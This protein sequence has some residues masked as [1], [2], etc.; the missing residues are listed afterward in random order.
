MSI[1]PDVDKTNSHLTCIPLRKTENDHAQKLSIYGKSRPLY[2]PSVTV[3]NLCFPRDPPPLQPG[4]FVTC[5]YRN[6]SRAGGKWLSDPTALRDR[7][8]GSGKGPAPRLRASD[9]APARPGHGSG[10]SH[11]RP[12]P[13][14]GLALGRARAVSS[15]RSPP[16]SPHAQI[17]THP[18]R[19]RRAP[20][21][22]G[23]LTLAFVFPAGSAF[24]RGRPA[25][26]RSWIARNWNRAKLE[27]RSE[28]APDALAPTCRP[29]ATRRARTFLPSDPGSRV[30]FCPAP[31]C[32]IR[33]REETGHTQGPQ[34]PRSAKVD[35]IRSVSRSKKLSKL[36]RPQ[37][38]C[39]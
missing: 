28:F 24:R 2:F 25:P 34:R 15:P 23:P 13:R 38:C 29:G 17:P 8:P 21:G 4:K 12:R 27:P 19:R 3:P 18:H 33:Q 32:E 20:A 1:H 11:P 22:S 31:V 36:T 10:A 35:I 9:S 5:S 37:S 16:R 30:C 6:S 14:P 26:S 7:L 39:S